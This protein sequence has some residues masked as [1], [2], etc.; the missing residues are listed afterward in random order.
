MS[1]YSDNSDD[2]ND[3]EQYDPFK[4]LDEVSNNI[5]KI[6]NDVIVNY[7]NNPNI[8]ILERLDKHDSNKFY[9]FFINNSNYYNT[10]ISDIKEIMKKQKKKKKIYKKR[11]RR[12]K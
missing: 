4:L 3:V 10:I 12:K 9:E 8:E 11:I 5:D 6:W 7:L 2:E 1:D